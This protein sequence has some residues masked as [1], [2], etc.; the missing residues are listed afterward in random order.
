MAKS[1][2]EKLDGAKRTFAGVL[3]ISSSRHWTQ[4]FPL[5]PMNA[6]A[7]P[8]DDLAADRCGRGVTRRAP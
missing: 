5:D 4:G 8:P 2:P 1:D 3:G 6:A 7:S